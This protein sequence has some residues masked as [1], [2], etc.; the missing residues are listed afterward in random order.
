VKVR[1]LVV[2]PLVAVLG[3]GLAGCDSKAGSAATV[4][5]HKISES[6]LTGYLTSQVKPIP[7]SSGEVP[8]R[9]FVLRTLIGNEVLPGFLAENGGQVTEEQVATAKSAV[10]AGRSEQAIVDQITGVGLSAKF[11]QVY[12]RSAELGSV[13]QSRFSSQAQFDAAVKKFHPAV[14]VNRRYGGWD[15]SSLSVRDFGSRELPDFVKI[16]GGLP[17]DQKQSQ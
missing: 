12:L 2:L 11:A 1:S 5:G 13:L 6:K 16:D 15:A 9:T 10:L 17:N 7:L 3:F 8:A 14:S 4:N